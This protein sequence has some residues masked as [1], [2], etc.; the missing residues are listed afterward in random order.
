MLPLAPTCARTCDALLDAS[1]VVLA[2]WTVVYDAAVLLHLTA[3]LALAVEAL[4]LALAVVGRV[5]HAQRGTSPTSPSV[6]PAGEPRPNAVGN[7]VLVPAVAT[8]V[9][10]AVVA[11]VGMAA[12]LPW[13]L[14]WVS[15]L[16]AAAASTLGAWSG[17]R[18]AGHAD[19]GSVAPGRG[20][21][22]VETLIVLAW[23]VGLAVFSTFTL[24]PNPDDLFYLNVSQWVAAHGAFPVRDTLFG[25]LVYP[26]S[27]WPP[28]ASYDGLTGAVA[29]L[30]GI[31]AGDVVYVVVTPLATFLAVLALWRLLRAWRV[32]SVAVALSATLIF[33][34]LDGTSA[35]GS[36]GNLFLTRL[37][38][39]KVILLCILVPT[40]L[41]HA[42]R[43]VERP[44]RTRAGWLLLGG[45]A[46]V[47]LSTTA[48]FLVPLIALAGA[49]PLLVRSTR[50]ALTGF[51]AMAGY[52]LLAGAVT[53]AVGGRSADD[54]GERRLYRFAPEWFGH[55]I[56]LTGIVAL[57]GVL[58]V[59]LGSLLL[60]HPAARLTTGL[61]V[62]IT[63]VTFVPGVTTSGYSLVGLGPTLWRVSWGC[64]IGA[65]V[66]V[67]AA[68]LLGLLRP[69]WTAWPAGLV[70]AAV[71]V[72]LGAPIWAPETSTSLVRP[73][74]WQRGAA[75]RSVTGWML[76]HTR[77]GDVVLAP[78]GLAIT[79]AATTTEIKTV[80]PRDYFMSYLR[81]VEAFRYSQRLTLVHLANGVGTVRPAD[82]GPALRDLDVAIACVYRTD[83][84]G[85]AAVRE[86]GYVERL[87]T[88]TYRCLLPAGR[89]GN[90]S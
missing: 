88:G 62:A 57:V 58:A 44:T 74:H 3:P 38:Q 6:T 49:A 36:P 59:L 53:L 24:R 31:P 51:G 66:G 5:A 77:P 2:S 46:A 18:G 12:S 89:A 35:Y 63:G 7:R 19:A 79:V 70:A 75:T 1:V 43:Y 83:R 47:G 52:P 76:Q 50:R 45:V 17:M 11:A 15:W 82:V 81:D 60:P 61:L 90:R 41:V 85:A 86:A 23:A 26:M 33:L 28:V 72:A 87:T 68:R 27:N 10:A 67:G 84:D 21:H 30:L 69:R 55:A 65:L 29:N 8:T 37:W 14:V 56:F 78:D 80:A 64:T 42:L 71:L 4:I 48:I 13:V 9:L 25:D 39:G 16:V 32:P 22:A 20:R 73:F 40:L 54:F 34:L